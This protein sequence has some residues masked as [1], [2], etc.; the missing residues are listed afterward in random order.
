M[1]VFVFA[2]LGP[3]LAN[4]LG[5]VAA[6]VGRQPWIV[7]PPVEW[8]AE[9]D[10]VVGSDGV[11]VYDERQGLR[12]ANAVSP[13]VSASQVLG[14]LI[15]FGFLYLALLATWLFVLCSLLVVTIYYPGLSGDY[16]FDDKSNLLDNRKLNIDTL[17]LESLPQLPPRDLS[18][19]EQ[20]AA[21]L[22][23][24]RQVRG[25]VPLGAH[26]RRLPHER[27]GK[28]PGHARCY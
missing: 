12:T 14:S 17:D 6:E 9:G 4:Q 19:E 20:L 1:W 26:L 13:A 22:V 18:E 11:V 28:G 2:V 27:I 21:G 23:P 24:A 15:G 16:M 25:P 8:T 7:H 3:L 10:V 5:W